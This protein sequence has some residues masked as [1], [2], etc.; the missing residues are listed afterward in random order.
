MVTCIFICRHIK[1][2]SP[3][4]N[5]LLHLSC[6][7][8]FISGLLIIAFFY[9]GVKGNYEKPIARLC[10]VSIVQMVFCCV[11]LASLWQI[12]HT[13]W[14]GSLVLFFTTL[15]VKNW[16]IYRIFY[17]PRIRNRVNMNSFSCGVFENHFDV[18]SI[19]L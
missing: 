7:G 15:L 12:S 14:Y 9:L 19:S 10:D 18:I 13:I 16:R 4:L 1:A 17:N 3:K 5:I 11:Q 6:C 8:M 2:T